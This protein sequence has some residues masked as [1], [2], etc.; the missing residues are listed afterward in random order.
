MTCSSLPYPDRPYLFDNIFALGSV[1][2]LAGMSGIGKTRFAFQLCEEIEEHSSILK[3]PALVPVRTIYFALDRPLAALHK[4]LNTMGLSK[5]LD[6]PIVSLFDRARAFDDLTLPPPSELQGYNLVIIDGIDCLIP[7]L[8]DSR[9]VG[10]MLVKCS[11]LAQA[12]QVAIL[13]LLGTAKVK[14]GE[15]YAHPRERIIGSSYWGRLSEEIIIIDNGKSEDPAM[16]QATIL[17]RNGPETS[18]VLAF[19]DGRLVPE[20]LIKPDTKD[21]EIF[22]RLPEIFDTFAAYELAEALLISRA[23]LFRALRKLLKNG[24]LRQPQQG[25][26]IKVKPN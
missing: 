8:T 3:I 10:R 18:F 4:T 12:K 7:K 9:D 6:T 2:L 17:R 16:R 11:K 15:G 14:E 25:H 24:L 21:L 20:N 22:E 13:G 23:T 19:E 26:Y 1:N 5:A